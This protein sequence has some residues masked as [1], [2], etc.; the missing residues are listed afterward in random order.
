MVYLASVG[1]SGKDCGTGGLWIG[2][3]KELGLTVAMIV[4]S[5]GQCIKWLMSFT[6]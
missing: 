6:R 4:I 1:T 2:K 3:L 5:K